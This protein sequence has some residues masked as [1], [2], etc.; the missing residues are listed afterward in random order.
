MFD[1]LSISREYMEQAPILSLRLRMEGILSAQ[2]VRNI[3]QDWL[4]LFYP[5]QTHLKEFWLRPKLYIAYEKKKSFSWTYRGEWEKI[6]FDGLDFDSPAYFVYFY[7]GFSPKM[8]K[9]L[10]E[11]D[12]DRID[13]AQLSFGINLKNKIGI[14][15]CPIEGGYLKPYMDS[16][17]VIET[18]IH[19]GI[20]QK[21]GL[22]EQ[23]LVETIKKW[24]TTHQN[25]FYGYMSNDRTV[26][27]KQSLI[28]SLCDSMLPTYPPLEFYVENQEVKT[29]QWLTF[30]PGNI[31]EKVPPK[32][33]QENPE[34]I[35]EQFAEGKYLIKTSKDMRAENPA[36]T[37]KLRQV[38][39]TALDVAD[40]DLP[41]QLSSKNGTI[42]SGNTA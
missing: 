41:K 38:L 22:D 12:I 2:K 5:Y 7:F 13:I 33:F 14:G 37:E 34:I 16:E 24:I 42:Y 18:K 26:L 28:A 9:K 15:Y 32:F 8:T 1:L 11:P 36:I 40:W 29:A 25:S 6:N 19:E 31:F 17:T 4:S 39:G 35:V 10:D 3:L 23:L 20:Y 21:I 27:T 30:V